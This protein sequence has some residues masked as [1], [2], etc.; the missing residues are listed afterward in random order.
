MEEIFILGGR[1]ASMACQVLPP[2]QEVR[3]QHVLTRRKWMIEPEGSVL[4]LVGM[5]VR[6]VLEVATDDEE[7][8]SLFMDRAE[9]T[10]EEV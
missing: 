5:H 9:S 6:E 4:Q 8:K 3:N 10:N 1:S 7:V 2:S